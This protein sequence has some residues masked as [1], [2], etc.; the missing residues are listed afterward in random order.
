MVHELENASADFIDLLQTPSVN[1]EKR[2][3]KKQVQ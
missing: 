2:T 1:R 3:Y